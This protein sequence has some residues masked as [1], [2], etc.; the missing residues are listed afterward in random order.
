[1]KNPTLSPRKFLIEQDVNPED[2]LAKWMEW[3]C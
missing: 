2:A 1:M 3:Y